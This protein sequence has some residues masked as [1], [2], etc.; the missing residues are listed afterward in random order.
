MRKSWVIVDFD[1]EYWVELP[2]DEDW[3]NTSWGSEKEWGK[4]AAEVLLEFK[5]IPGNRKLLRRLEK[6]LI[7][8]R[9]AFEEHAPGRE[10]YLYFRDLESDPL[11]MHLW[12]GP[13]EDEREVAL[14]RNA[15]ADSTDTMFPPQVEEVASEALGTGLRSLNHVLLEDQTV[16]ANLW[17]A[18]RDDK[19]EVDLIALASSGNLG[20]F[21]AAMSDFDEFVQSISLYDEGN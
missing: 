10:H 3:R 8:Y 21:A 14:R 2:A 9:R 12:Y 1:Y 5:D 16:A 20:P 13:A 7:G 17:Y 19:R 11:S 4:S 6:E 15:R 18:F